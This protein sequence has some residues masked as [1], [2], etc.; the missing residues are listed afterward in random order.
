MPNTTAIN[1]VKIERITINFQL[2]LLFIK[3]IKMNSLGENLCLL[4]FLTD[5]AST[6]PVVV[7]VQ[8]KYLNCLLEYKT[9]P[10]LKK[11]NTWLLWGTFIN[12]LLSRYIVYRSFLV[13]ICLIGFNAIEKIFVMFSN[14]DLC[15]NVFNTT[16]KVSL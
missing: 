7:D 10:G 2:F 16:K 14:Q 8:D 13:Y 12:V 1:K 4:L 15:D 9:T 11:T 3:W 5:Y 6:W